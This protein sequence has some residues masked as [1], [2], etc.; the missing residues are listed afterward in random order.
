MSNYN[1]VK[2]FAPMIREVVLTKRMPPGQIDPTV[3][4]FKNGYALTSQQIQKLVHWV[5]AGAKKDS[6]ID[7]LTELK[8][9]ASKWTLG[10]PDLIVKVPPQKI[11]ATGVLTLIDVNV[12][13]AG[14]DRDRYVRASE[15]LPSERSVLH[16]TVTG[17]L[18]P[19]ADGA[20]GTFTAY[21]LDGARIAAYTPGALPLVEP[22]NTGGLLKKGSSLALNLHYTTNGK[23]TTDAS[24]IG[25]WFYPDDQVPTERM[26][27]QCACALGGWKMIP[28]FASNHEMQ[29]TVTLPK[30]AVVYSLAP[31]MHFRGKR[32]RFYA[33]YVDGTHE[34]LLNIANYQYNWQYNY[35]LTTPKRMPA[36]TKITAIAA[37]DNSVQNKANPDP[38]RRVPFGEQSWDEMMFGTITLKYVD[39][40]NKQSNR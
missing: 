24:E 13:I 20:S 29:R 3:G 23:A 36:G 12:P 17:V 1:I 37:F 2:G 32:M 5:D 34:E 19:T 15:Y 22:A 26:S 9:P 16:H 38:S 4:H 28:P 40:A 39:P 25:I 8:W 18:P 10:E 11:P 21:S 35:E 7:P 31:H 14:L 6:D 27:M 30:D 33:D